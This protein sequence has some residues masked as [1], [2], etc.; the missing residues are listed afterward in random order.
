MRADEKE[1]EVFVSSANAKNPYKVGDKEHLEGSGLYCEYVISKQQMLNIPNALKSKQWKNNPD[2][3]LNM[4]SYL[5]LPVNWPDGTSFGT[6]CVL[7]DKEN[8]YSPDAILLLD[9][10]R[11]LVES[12]LELLVKNQQLIELASTDVLTGVLNRRAFFETAEKE[13]E[14]AKRYNKNVSLIIFDVDNF[15]TINDTL[16]HFSGDDVL[17]Q[18][19]E[20]VNSELRSSDI[21]GR[22]GGDEFLILLP[23]KNIS[24][25]KAVAN[26]LC[27]E[28]ESSCVTSS[29]NKIGITI[30]VGVVEY[31]EG[32]SVHTLVG[33]A[34]TMLHR[35]KNIGRNQICAPKNTRS[36]KCTHE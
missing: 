21:F 1:I 4:I 10:M 3:R 24:G 34:D 35:A 32:D 26:R 36:I 28:I 8:V 12:G 30:S 16:G 22:F 2:I 6:I 31:C 7:D 29:E 5:G 11:E 25:A 17:V 23:E 14:R 27:S 18:L 19:A 20:L 9:K 13:L 15:K 33:L